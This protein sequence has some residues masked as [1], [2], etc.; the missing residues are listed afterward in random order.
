MCTNQLEL[1][2]PTSGNQYVGAVYWV[3]KLSPHP[4]LNMRSSQRMHLLPVVVRGVLAALGV[5]DILVVLPCG[6]KWRVVVVSLTNI[7]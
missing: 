2:S 3:I 7:G 4:A 1:L 5:C 6:A